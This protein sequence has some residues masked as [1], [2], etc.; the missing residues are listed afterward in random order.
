VKHRPKAYTKDDL[1][2]HRLARLDRWG[3]RLFPLPFVGAAI[4]FPSIF[5][6]IVT[7]VDAI[8]S[9]GVILF[10]LGLG[11]FA[12]GALGQMTVQFFMMIERGVQRAED[13]MANDDDDKPKSKKKK[14]K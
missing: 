9:V 4:L 5:I 11:I 12:L 14:A 10:V 2:K 3:N 1:D 6:V 8:D 13:F 7:D